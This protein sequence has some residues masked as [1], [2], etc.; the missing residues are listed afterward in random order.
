MLRTA[1]TQPLGVKL[2]CIKLSHR[3]FA[4]L[5]CR[6]TKVRM[7]I[8]L[9]NTEPL[10]AYQQDGVWGHDAWWD[11]PRGSPSPH[12]PVEWEA[13][14]CQEATNHIKGG[15]QAVG[16]EGLEEKTLEKRQ[17]WTPAGQEAS[18][19]Q[20]RGNQEENIHVWDHVGSSEPTRTSRP[21]DYN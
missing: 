19:Q 10:T 6:F 8:Y 11:E 12:I 20:K 3:I 7:I 13:D 1:L 16:L 15:K 17:P 5:D 2:D 18:G 9:R 14:T 4:E 21:N